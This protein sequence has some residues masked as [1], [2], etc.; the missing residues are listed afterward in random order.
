MRPGAGCG[1]IPAGTPG[2][3]GRKNSRRA[4]CEAGLGERRAEVSAWPGKLREGG[5]GLAGPGPVRT[6]CPGGQSGK[7][8]A[9]WV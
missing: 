3:S 5:R 2:A 9:R 6:D 4:G 7:T 8:G 1:I